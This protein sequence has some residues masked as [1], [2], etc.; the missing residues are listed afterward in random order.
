MPWLDEGDKKAMIKK[1][2]SKEQEEALVKGIEAWMDKQFATFGKW[3]LF[4]IAAG[5][6][7][8]VVLWRIRLAGIN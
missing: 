6:F 8:Y 5:V 3:T 7:G 2:L 1:G 4:W